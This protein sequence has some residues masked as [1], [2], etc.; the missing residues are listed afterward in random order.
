MKNI[1]P[2]SIILILAASLTSYAQNDRRGFTGTL[3]ATTTTVNVSDTDEVESKTNEETTI[4]FSSRTITIGSEVYDI[5]TREFDSKS[6]NTF[7]CTKRRGSY[8]LVYNTNKDLTVINNDDDE[9][10][11]VYSGITEN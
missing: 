9:L 8:T 4:E 5:V 2:L 6:T 7:K 10:R 3:T 1:I 11:T